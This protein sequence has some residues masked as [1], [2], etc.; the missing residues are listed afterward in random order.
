MCRA[1]DPQ[2]IDPSVVDEIC[3][4]ARRHPSAGNAQGLR[5]LVLEGDR[6][7]EFWSLTLPEERRAT[8]RWQ[9]L[10]DA[11]VLIILLADPSVYLA[12]YAEPDK[13][14]S[15][16][17]DDLGSWPTPYWTVDSAM[18]VMLALLAAEERGLGALFFALF[19]GED[20]VRRHFGVP[21]HLQTLGVLAI[22]HPAG[23]SNAETGTGRSASRP[24]RPLDEVVR[25]GRWTTD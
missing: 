24:R 25:R 2:P 1:F 22:G 20:E 16:L 3:D 14:R 18:G 9:R 6:C 21:G 8:F 13:A 12:R 4:L 19:S 10:L 5:M 17:G 23:G 7:R 15:G 11:P